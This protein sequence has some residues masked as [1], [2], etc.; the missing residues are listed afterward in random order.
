MVESLEE[1][2][3]QI[4]VFSLEMKTAFNAL[5][6]RFDELFFLHFGIVLPD[7]GEQQLEEPSDWETPDPT[8]LEACE[9]I[10]INGDPNPVSMEGS[11]TVE[12]ANLGASKVVRIVVEPDLVKKQ[13]LDL[14]SEAKSEVQIL[15]VKIDKPFLRPPPR[16][17][18]QS[19]AMSHPQIHQI[20]PYSRRFQLIP[21]LIRLR[22]QLRDPLCCWK[23]YRL[24]RCTSSRDDDLFRGTP[25]EE[26][27]RSEEQQGVG[28]YVVSVDICFTALCS[29]N[30]LECFRFSVMEV[31]HHMDYEG[32]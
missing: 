11:L 16:Q 13:S 8:D 27:V 5:S 2:K 14:E 25:F 1:M 26:I 6:R 24:Q 9:L 10:S 15:A 17:P 3:N 7:M 21:L 31:V 19:T 30:D 23:F 32:A 12:V 18:N 20:W 4:R 28:L 22:D 29:I